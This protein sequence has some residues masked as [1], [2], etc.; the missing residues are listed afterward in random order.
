MVAVFDLDDSIAD[1]D[2]AS[3]H[4]HSVRFDASVGVGRRAVNVDV[5]TT[6]VLV[7][8]DVLRG[9]V[10]AVRALEGPAAR[11]SGHVPP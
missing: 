3:I 1:G 2:A 7:Q 10:L 11:V 6:D 9:G 8:M 4:V 5:Y